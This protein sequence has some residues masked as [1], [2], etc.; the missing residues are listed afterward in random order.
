M[1]KMGSNKVSLK[2]LVGILLTVCFGVA[3]S[4]RV[5]FPYD[6][7]FTSEGIKFTGVDA[8]FQMRIVDTIVHNFPHLTA[9][10]PYLMYPGLQKLGSTHFFNWLLSGIIW[11][12]GLGSP[13]QH[14]IDVV[15]VY[16][17]AILGALVVIPVFFIGRAL[18]NRWVGLLAA[19]LIAIL[20]GE[21]MGRS[22]LGF[23]DQHIAEVLFSTVAVLFLI[24]AIKSARQNGL[25]YNHLWQRDWAAS[26]RPLVYALLAGVF[27]GIYL[28]T[29]VGSLLFVFILALY[30]VIQFIVDHLRGQSTDYLG[31]TGILL[32]LI[33]LLL[34]LPFSAGGFALASIYIALLMVLVLTGVSRLATIRGVRPVYYPLTLLGLGVVGVAV[35]YAINPSLFRIMASQFSIFAPT[36]AMAEATLEMQP[37]LSPQGNFSIAVA[38]GNYTTGFFFSFITLAVLIYLAV[39]RGPA[40]WNLLLVWSVVI[41]AATLGQRRF[42]YYFAV[43]VALLTGYFAWQFLQL[44]RLLTDWLT[45]RV[46]T[47]LFRR[48]IV[49]SLRMLPVTGARET[50]L[51]KHRNESSPLRYYFIPLAV[52]IVIVFVYIL[53]ITAAMAVASKARFAPSD[54]WQSS[55]VWMR[56]NTPEPFG[57]PGA[58][59]RLYEPPP[60]RTM[61]RPG[62]GASVDKLREWVRYL[63]N[64]YDY[65]ESAY[66]VVSWWDYGYWVSR[67]AHRL[68]AATPGQNVAAL[69]LTAHFLLSQDEAPAREIIQDWRS[70][71]VILDHMT[72]TSK[73]WAIAL[74][75]GKD[76]NEF[77]GQ[78]YVSYEGK[79]VPV[80]VFHPG[81]YQSLCARLYNF[82]GKAV[83]PEII[84]VI[85][86]EEKVSSKGQ[87][88]KQITDIN[89][90]AD[91]SE[92]LEF[93]NSQEPDS[94]RIVGNDQF[95]SPVPLEAVTD[96]ELVHS[97]DYVVGQPAG[98]S[99][100]EVKIFEFI[101]E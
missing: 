9:F 25:T 73:F 93:I 13:S 99:I 36:G 69:T 27:L 63:R 75:A 91:Y 87:S 98:G 5:Y 41:L 57:D 15:G 58:Y 56:E 30:F 2:L 88:F 67:I 39:K 17:P 66:G 40:E 101:G 62:E 96:F 34:F 22:I 3:L 82:D 47:A 23:T 11:V 43:N 35:F 24:L 90:F 33:A 31:I 49:E 54:A 42:A 14:L 77:V 12:I 21:F 50:G 1:R 48:Q 52:I 68:P 61:G 37:L 28:I 86:Y 89:T 84:P 53:N 79:L 46:E 81:Y 32:F 4:L 45:S 38:W 92:A 70:S 44:V 19:A 6:Q 26:T 95:V 94:C 60:P 100:P 59:Y 97:S 80:N 16:F 78:Y 18:F 65:P 7:V 29:W 10:D 74:W 72:T 51:K 85:S 20:P 71:Y 64:D 76:I 55:L 83:T 8:Y